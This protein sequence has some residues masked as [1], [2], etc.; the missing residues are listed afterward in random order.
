MSKPEKLKSE[1]DGPTEVPK[2]P[3]GAG[4]IKAKKAPTETD[5]PQA[6]PRRTPKKTTEEK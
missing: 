4:P 3:F 1:P 6:T 5:E 2:Y